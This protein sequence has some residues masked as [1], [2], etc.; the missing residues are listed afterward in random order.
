MTKRGRRV[1]IDLAYDGTEF[2][3]WQVQPGQRTVQGTVEEALSRIESG[4]PVR[5]R[6]AGRTDAG[7][8]A[9]QQVTDVWL[10]TTHE[11][12]EIASRLRSMLPADVR[13]LA[14]RTTTPGF[15]ARHDATRK[16]YRY[17][18]DRSTARDPFLN[19]FALHY[20]HTLDRAALDDALARLPGKKDW[21]GFAGAASEVEDTVRHLYEAT[22]MEPSDAVG[23]FTFTADGFLTYMIRNLVGT[24]LDIARGRF[25]PGRIDR[26]LE[27]GDRTLAGPTAAARGLCLVQVVYAAAAPPPRPVLPLSIASDTLPGRNEG[28]E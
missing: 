5:V 4:R 16:T 7:V 22:Y 2:A 20:P 23:V 10:E 6:A 19:R 28:E 17:L 26:V 3:G 25:A 12:A 13:P 15:H 11:D 9:R 1:R 8:H 27:T 21:S 14:L 24:I 18:L